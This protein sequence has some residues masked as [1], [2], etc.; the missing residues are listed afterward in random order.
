MRKSFAIGL[1]FAAVLAVGSFPVRAE[2][3]TTPRNSRRRFRTRASHSNKGSRLARLKAS[4]S[5]A[6]SRLRTAR[7]SYLC[8]Q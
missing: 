4:Q 8:T 2:A 6:N 1:A 5:R 3:T 7:F